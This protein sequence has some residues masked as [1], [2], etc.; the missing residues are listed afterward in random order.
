MTAI[1]NFLM[2]AGA[3][4]GFIF[5]VGTFLSRRKIEK[6]IL[7]L[8]LFVLF[9]S[10]NNLQ[11][12]FLEKRFIPAEFEL[13]DFT[14][15]WYVLIVPMFYAFLVYYLKIEQ[16]RFSFLKISIGIFCVELM[17]RSTIIYLV[18]SGFWPQAFLDNYNNIEDFVTLLYSLFLFYKAI[19]LVFG[20]GRLLSPIS[21]FDDLK[22]LKWF[23]YLGGVVFV[24]WIMSIV[25][26][27][28]GL[29]QKPYS[30]Y[31]LRLGSSL[32]IYWVGY[33]GFFRYVV[34]KDRILLR[35]EIRKKM[36]PEGIVK[37]GEERGADVFSKIDDYILKNQKFLEPHLSLESLSEEL[38]KSTSSLSK[39]MNAC[40]GGNF[41][42]Y[43]NKYRVQ[44]AKRLLADAD[45][46]AYTIVAIGLECGFNSKSTF[47]SAFKKFTGV[48]PTAFRKEAST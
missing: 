15:P 14:I 23:F 2:I 31:P 20:E 32:L 29:V 24:L 17:A 7:F 9:L 10:L 36:G 3:V 33:Q 45:F 22:W 34:L 37:K 39:L 27:V 18:N 19:Q 46:S 42:D 6:P 47:Y 25:L 38:G 1:F 41:S 40:A 11:S 28:T 43:V 44:E 30:Y 48:T 13:Q 8:N 35:K 12:W 4:Q 16:E 26:N 5:N 21:N